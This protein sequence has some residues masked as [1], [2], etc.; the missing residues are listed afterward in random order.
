VSYGPAYSR[1]IVKSEQG[2]RF[3]LPSQPLTFFLTTPSPLSLPSPPLPPLPHLRSRPQLNP[4]RG[5]GGALVSNPSGVWGGAP[6]EIEF[7]AQRAK[8]T[9]NYRMHD[10]KLPLFTIGVILNHAFNA[11]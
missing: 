3:P 8:A 11:H 5:F 6:A 10:L 7:G 1:L 4:A 2:E 9:T